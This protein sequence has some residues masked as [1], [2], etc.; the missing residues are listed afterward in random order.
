MV[1]G[2]RQP[3]LITGLGLTASV[4]LLENLNHTL[5]AWGTV[6]VLGVGAVGLSNWWLRQKTLQSLDLQP[7]FVDRATVETALTEVKTVMSQL[8]QE[9]DETE[10]S[11]QK[12]QPVLETLQSQI[13]QASAEMERDRIRFGVMGGKSVGKTSLFQLLQKEW[14]TSA[15]HKLNLRDT[16]GLFDVSATDSGADSAVWQSI[17]ECDLI[18]FVV[19]G[20][21][22]EPEF[23]ALSRVAKA[24]KRILLVFNKQD[25]YLP[26]EQQLV[27]ERLRERVKRLLQSED[28]V[29]IAAQPSPIKVR[30]YQADGSVQERL[31]QPS[32]EIVPLTERLNQILLQEGQQLVLASCLSTVREIQSQARSTLNDIRRIKALPVIEKYQWISAATAF[33]SPFPALDVLATAAINA[34]MVLDLSQLYQQKFSL[35]QA[36]TIAGTMASL[37]LKLGLVELSVQAVTGLLKSNAVTFVAGGAVQGVSA[38]YLTRL[39]GLSLVEYFQEQATSSDAATLDAGK[40]KRLSETLQNLF[41]QNQRAA[42]LKTF[43]QQAVS[44]LTQANPQPLPASELQPVSAQPPVV[45]SENQ[46]TILST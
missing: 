29:S 33:A 6:C 44:Y 21:L 4:W 42:F 12:V 35:Q 22:T 5:G 31:D 24:Q 26:S 41:Q 19:T 36:Q 7:R 38:A 13:T 23:Q 34:Q 17:L 25:Q 10:D 8:Q 15:G 14:A 2:I 39:A 40:L 37:L 32:P 9:A 45:L 1:L 30:Q 27:V 16:P 11:R 20:D 3:I 43:V 28:V 46:A 18:L